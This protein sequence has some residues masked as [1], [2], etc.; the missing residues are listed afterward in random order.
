MEQ[1]SIFTE[2][3]E[4]PGALS[5]CYGKDIGKTVKVAYLGSVVVAQGDILEIGKVV[6]VPHYEWTRLADDTYLAFLKR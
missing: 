3:K 5:G 2:P 4:L 1:V 6:S